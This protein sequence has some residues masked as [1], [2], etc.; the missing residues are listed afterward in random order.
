MIE[1]AIHD[2]EMQWR[3]FAASSASKISGS[4]LVK[5]KDGAYHL[6][7]N[8][9]VSL[10]MML[11]SAIMAD[12]DLQRHLATWEQRWGILVVIHELNQPGVQTTPI[13]LVENSSL[14]L[15]STDRTSSR[16]E[17]PPRASFGEWFK[18]LTGLALPIRPSKSA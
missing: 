2:W 17:N 15:L 11:A 4:T 18:K 6:T 14:L 9:D 8:T 10:P 5:E 3:L 16:Q 12:A 7:L 13:L 1:S